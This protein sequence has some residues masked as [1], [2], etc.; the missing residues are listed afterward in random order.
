[1]SNVDITGTEWETRKISLF[2]VAKSFVSQ[3]SV[4]QDLTK[5]SLPAI[6]LN[7]Y[8]FVGIFCN[9]L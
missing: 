1:M 3:L 6:F 5:V 8:I 9:F 4:G 7:P 2:G